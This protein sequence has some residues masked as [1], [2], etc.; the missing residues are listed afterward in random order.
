MLICNCCHTPQVLTLSYQ[1]NFSLLEGF[2]NIALLQILN[3][4]I[5]HQLNAPFMKV[6]PLSQKVSDEEV[7]LVYHQHPLALLKLEYNLTQK[8]TNRFRVIL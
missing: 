7:A 3:I 6:V 2:Q 4:Q 5:A 8:A 1:M